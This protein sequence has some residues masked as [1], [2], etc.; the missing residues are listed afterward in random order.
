M[1]KYSKFKDPLTGINPFIQ[2]KQKALDLK[3][4]MYAIIRLPIYILYLLGL[5]VIGLLIK[6]QKKCNLKPKG[7]IFCNS[8]SE[9]DE[10]IIKKAFKINSFTKSRLKTGVYFPEGARSNNTM[11]LSYEGESDYAIGLKY[12]S[13]CVYTY[14]SRIGW[15]I[16]FLGSDNHVE[17]NVIEGSDLCKATKLPKSVLNSEDKKRFLELLNKK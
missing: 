8:A 15:L 9:F 2:P 7:L 16:R 13:E 11:I 1:E 5:P 17:V 10:E 3:T 12:N 6:I 14:G 4:V